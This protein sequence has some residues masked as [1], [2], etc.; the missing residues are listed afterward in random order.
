MKKIIIFSL[1]LLSA[2][3]VFAQTAAPETVS[4]SGKL[5]LVNGRIVLQSGEN[6]YYV[7]GIGRLVGFIDGLKEGAQVSLEGYVRNEPGNVWV[8]WPVKLTLGGKSYDLAPAGSERNGWS[9]QGFHH[10]ER[11]FYDGPCGGYRD[12]GGRRGRR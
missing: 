5:A 8:L 9:R 12:G 7:A 10:R 1:L 2:A 3:L 6:L 4:V 11:R